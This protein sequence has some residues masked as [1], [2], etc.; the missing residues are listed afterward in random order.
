MELD[1]S[2]LKEV[3]Q[4]TNDTQDTSKNQ[5]LRGTVKVVGNDKFVQLDGSSSLTPISNTVD[6][7]EDDRVLVSI[8]NHKAVIIGNFTFPPSARKEQEAIDKADEAQNGANN[9]SDKADQA[10]SDSSIASASAQEAKDQANQAIEAA[11][12][13]GTNASEAKDLAGKAVSDATTAKQQAAEAQSNVAN[14]QTEINR[15]NGE[16]T[17]VKEDITGALTDLEAQAAEIQG[18]KETMSTEYSKKTEVSEVEASLK[19]EISKKV[20]EL[21]TTVEETYAAKSEVTEIQ[22]QLQ[23]QIT[24]NANDI[25]SHAS[26][27]ETLESDTAQAQED[28]NKALANAAAAQSTADTAKANASAAQQAADN[29]QSAADTAASKAQLAQN[30]ADAANAAASAADQKVQSAQSDLNEAKQ[31]LANVT[32]RVDA[33]EAD[34]AEAQSKV[35]AAQ[36]AVNEALADAAEANLAASNA[37]TAA[38]QAQADATAAQQAADNAQTKA[39]QAQTAADNAQAA[40]DQAQADVAALTKRVTTA[41]T[42]ITQNAEQIALNATKTEEIGDDLKNNYYTKTETEAQIKLSADSIT[43]TVSKT[44]STKSE[45]VT[46]EV[47]QFYQSTSP[48]ALVGGSWSNTQP[49]WTEGTYIWRRTL[50]TKADGS[51]SYT[52]SQNGVC[53][54]GNTGVQGPAG[55]DGK[56]ISSSNVTY[57]ASSSGTTPPT[58]TWS[59]SIPTVSQGQYLWTRTIT[60]YTDGNSTTSYSVAYIPKNGTD[61]NDG[62][63]GDTGDAGTGVASIT[64]QWYVSTSKTEQVDGE[65]IETEPTWESGKYLWRRF[66]IVYENPSSTV[67]TTA[68][69]DSSWEAVNEVTDD[70]DRAQSTADQAQLDAADTNERITYAE[71]VIQQLSDSI[72]MLVTDENGAS[73]MTQTEDGWTFNMGAL[74]N[75]VD[76]ATTNIDELKKQ[77]ENMNS[78]L[79]SLN[80]TVNDHGDTLEYVQI[81]VFED[82]PCIELGESDSDSKLLITNTRI[83]FK[84]GSNTGTYIDDSGFVT[85]NTTINGELRQGN[86]VWK[87]RSNG[88]YGLSWIEVS[89]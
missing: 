63:K 86:F 12:T 22:G 46:S 87:Q 16:V 40:A 77:Y 42:N 33:T 31:N 64:P 4:V 11:N 34:I 54:T 56:G 36:T 59:S 35:D 80:Q 60:T 32:S 23:T 49:T 21:Q 14:A 69:C 50:V 58:G 68:E 3:A 20:G 17:A 13:A 29:A 82:E 70:I 85:D 8:E 78:I 27:I 62:T 88:H 75:T 72:S 43:S 79:D 76:D 57:Q 15:I 30:A 19:T 52:P 61:G 74:Q 25:S 71:S 48:T 28:V 7:D 26:K 41:E 89:S 2:L 39:N 45:T 84:R 18:V 9:A 53:I 66:K 83:I 38:D 65:W 5:Y 47:E 73:L 51:T 6:V 37:Q 44:Y 55:S 67:Y 1:R 10:I 81:G 24:Q